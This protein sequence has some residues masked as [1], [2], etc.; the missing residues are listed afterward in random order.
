MLFLQDLKRTLLKQDNLIQANAE[1]LMQ[2]IA[3]FETLLNLRLEHYFK[4]SY[5]LDIDDYPAPNL[6]ASGAIYAQFVTQNKLK[7]S[8]RLCLILAILP[9]IK[10]S[11]LEPL[12]IKNEVSNT[13]FSEFG[14]E[15]AKA[16]KGFLPTIQTY[17]FIACGA[18]LGQRFSKLGL[19]EKDAILIQH[20]IISLGVIEE[21]D[22]QISAALL[23]EKN[24][25]RA[26]TLGV[27]PLSDVPSGNAKLRMNTSLEWDDL[28]LA[29][30]IKRELADALTWLKHRKDLAHYKGLSKHVKRGYKLLLHGKAGTGKST[31][32][33]LLGV[34]ANMDVYRFDLSKYIGET[35]KN[36]R[37]LF[38]ST[39]TNG[40]ILFFD[41]ADAFIKTYGE[42]G[43]RDNRHI[44]QSIR[45]FLQCIAQ[46]D[47]VVVLSGESHGKL[48]EAFPRRFHTTIYFPMPNADE[49]EAFLRQLLADDIS[50]LREV[51]LSYFAQTF[52]MSF[53]AI[54][55]AVSD[56]V[57]QM[58]KHR[59]DSLSHADLIKSFKKVITS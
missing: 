9:H 11:S 43:T 26:F 52:E 45:Y 19:F 5:T 46:Y 29:P 27:I 38:K 56:A 39:Q 18:S 16:H 24:Y 47:G 54:A 25:L 7:D 20:N 37:R 40:A 32:V 35:E 22:V 23:I 41:K 10:P 59:R 13:Y 15:V 6:S 33:A 14:G 44:H 58:K 1:A 2:E 17:L 51:D 49:R 57:V 31:V 12:L 42:I 4:D 55:D 8:Q 36:L 53:G 3:W 30:S 28:I 48:D 34:K 50:V 21:N